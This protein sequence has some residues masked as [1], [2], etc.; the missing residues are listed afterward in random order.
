MKKILL[1]IPSLA[2]I[3]GTER[4]VVALSGMFSNAGFDVSIAAFDP[5]GTRPFFKCDVPFHPMGRI[6]RLPLP[7]RA[8]GYWI[9]IRKLRDLKKKLGTDLTVS[10]LWGADLISILSGGRD[11]KLCVAHIN[12]VGNPTNRLMV[13]LR[14]LVA[15]IYRKADR[16]VAVSQPLAVELKALYRLDEDRIASIDNFVDRP[17]ATRY[18]PDD[19]IKRFA[20][21]GRA[22][23]EKNLQ[24]LLAIW[25]RFVAEHDNVQL[26]LLGD[27]PLLEEQV[28]RA[29]NLGLTVST[30]LD[31]RA[32]QVIFAGNV[33]RPADYLVCARAMLLTSH[34]EGLPMVLL[35][36]L[37]LGIPIL[38]SD[39]PSGGVR[40]VMQS[41]HGANVAQSVPGF[42]LPVP[43]ASTGSGVSQWCDALSSIAS[44]D[45]LHKTFEEAALLRAEKFSSARA[46]QRWDAELSRLAATQ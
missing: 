10:H 37:S 18:W 16:V 40:A 12:V 26:V 30:S 34:A 25:V 42:L 39:C 35:E 6:R 45:S 29:R 44:D 27:G 5:P 21:C 32:A 38:A 17:A 46:S 11:R 7:L 1:L 41:D 14:P 2:G 8:V 3:G 33:S 20:W 28:S 24:G 13:R 9:A 23:A 43:D 15:W 31:D 22:V 36:A 4:M 19:G